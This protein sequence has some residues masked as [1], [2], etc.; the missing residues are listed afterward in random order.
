MAKKNTVSGKR[1]E[2]SSSMVEFWK[3]LKTKLFTYHEWNKRRKGQSFFIIR[4]GSCAFIGIENIRFDDISIHS[5]RG[6]V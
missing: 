6:K 5:P 1:L 3:P 4:L 2:F